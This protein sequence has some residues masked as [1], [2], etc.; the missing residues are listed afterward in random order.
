MAMKFGIPEVD[1]TCGICGKPLNTGRVEDDDCGGDCLECMGR[2]GDPAAAEHFLLEV[3]RLR[4]L[5][6]ALL[7][8][9]HDA[10]VQKLARKALHPKE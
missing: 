3:K 9:L 2:A 6:E 10:I 4:E 5:I 8:H 1:N 7:D